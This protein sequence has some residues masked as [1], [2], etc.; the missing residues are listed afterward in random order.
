MLWECDKSPRGFQK[1]EELD[2]SQSR[3]EICDRFENSLIHIFL[4]FTRR[5]ELAFR[6][7]QGMVAAFN[8]VQKIWRF[9]LGSDPLQ[10]IQRT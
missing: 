6:D 7:A 9:H 1:V 8:H 3:D 2:R 4:R 10:Q 5:L